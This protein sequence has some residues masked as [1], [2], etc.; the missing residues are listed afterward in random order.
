MK[1]TY[2]L[3]RFHCF[4]RGLYWQ[5][6]QSRRRLRQSLRL[7]SRRKRRERRRPKKMRAG[8]YAGTAG[9]GLKIGAT[10]QDLGQFWSE[11]GVKEIETR[12][13]EEGNTFTAPV[14]CEDNSS[15]QIEQ[16][17]NFISSECDVILVHPSDPDA[18]ENGMQEKRRT[19]G[20]PLCAGTNLMTNS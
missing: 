8:R 7:N 2:C 5:D 9:A 17:E 20:F 14:S 15:K 3:W 16:I 11:V 12:A 18:I 19:K 6:A 10:I 1:K 13:S 4:N